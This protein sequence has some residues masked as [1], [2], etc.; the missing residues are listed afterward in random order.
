MPSS[1][2]ARLERNHTTKP[3]P[4]Q[5]ADRVGDRDVV[6]QP[7]LLGIGRSSRLIVSPAVPMTVDSV[8]A[9]AIRPAAVPAS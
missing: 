9:P 7:R 8:N 1:F 3:V 6:Q 5:V 2:G 4:D